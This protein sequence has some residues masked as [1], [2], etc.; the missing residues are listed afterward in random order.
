[1]YIGNTTILPLALQYLLLT[2]EEVKP[3]LVR[4]WFAQFPAVKLVNAYGP[5]EASDDITHYIMDKAPDMERIP[6]GRPLPNM[7]IYIVDYNMQLCPIGMKGEIWVSG[8]GVGRGYLGDDEKTKHV[9]MADPFSEDK[10]VRLY[11]TGDLGSWLADGNIEFF[12]RKDHQVKIRGFR[13]ELEE[14]ENKLSGH[15]QIKAVVVA[16]NEDKTGNKYLCAYI[17]ARSTVLPGFTELKD[18][19][20]ASL[21][22][23][24]IPDYFIQ[25]EKIPLTSNGKIDRKALPA[26]GLKAGENDAAPRT[27]IEKKMAALWAEIL[28]TSPGIDDNFFHLGGHSL[29]AT[30]LISKIHKELNVVIPLAELFKNPTIRGL[31]EYIMGS[32]ADIY[33]SIRPVEKR[34]YYVLSF[35]QKRMYILQKIDLNNIAY[36]MPQMIPLPGEVDNNRL[37]E[38]FR[39]LIKRHESLRTSFH[40]LEEQP[41]QRIHDHVEFK[42]EYYHLSPGYRTNKNDNVY[43]FIRAFDLTKAPLLR[44]GLVKTYEGKQYLLVDMHHIISDGISHQVLHD[45]FMAFY[46]G[47][48]LPAL[49]LQYKDFSQWQND[50][51]EKEKLKYQEE[52]WLKEF[53]GEQPVLDLP[54][55]YPRPLMQ[56]FE[57][58]TLVFE[59]PPGETLALKALAAQQGATLFMV[60]AAVLDILLAKL[61]GQ[62]DIIIGVPVAGRRHVDL[63]KIIGMFVNTL[64]LRNFP[65]GEKSFPGFLNELKNRTLEAFENQ[66]Y[67]FEDLVEKVVTGRDLGRNPLFD[68][69]FMVENITGIKNKSA[70]KPLSTQ[71][72]DNIIKIA[73]FDLEIEAWEAGPVLNIMFGYCTKLFKKE[74]IARFIIY[75]KKIAALVG[76]NPDLKIKDIEIISD[77]EKKQLVVEFNQTAAA[78]PQDKTIMQL[79]AGQAEKS[80]DHIALIGPVQPVQPVQL[81]RHFNLTYRQL[82]EQSDRVAN[83]L[84]EK[85]VLADDIIGIMMERSTQMITAILGIFKSGGAYLPID[86]QS[87]PERIAYMLKDSNAKIVLNMDHFDLNSLKECPRR[88]CHHSNHLAYIIYTSGSTGKPKG[89]M[90]EHTG[91]INHIGAKVID[92]QITKDSVIV[93][94]ASHTFDISV[95]QFFAA[96]TRGG[97]TVIYPDEL[98]LDPARFIARFN[99]DQITILEV[100]PSYLSVIMNLMKDKNTTPCHL[101]YLLVT[102]EEVKPHTVKQW[103]ELHPGIKVVNAYGPTEASDDITHHI[104]DKVPDNDRIPIGKPVQNM[105]I[106]IVD[107]YMQLCPIGVKGEIWVSGIGVG[108]GYLNEVHKTSRVFINDPFAKEEGIRLYKTGDLGRWLADGT[109]E[110]FGRTDYQ[111]KIR[112]FRVEPGEIENRLLNHPGIKEVVVIHRAESDKNAYLGAYIVSDKKYEIAQLREYLAHELPDYM[113]P[114]FFVRVEKIP[115]TPNGKLDRKA[116]PLP[117]VEEISSE[118]TPPGNE[119]EEKLAQIWATVLGT[120]KE[121]ISTRQ[122]FF[123]MG[124]TSLDLI[125][126]L[127]LIH[128]EFGI[129]VTANQIYHNPT[130]QAI[131]KSIE[132]N[133]YVDEPVMLLN[134]PAPKKIF[135]FPPG[136]GF[137]IAYQAL[138]KIINDYSLYSFNFIEDEN[139]LEQYAEI[140]TN[141][142]PTAPYILFGWS[143]AGKLIFEVAAVLEN[144]GFEVS[145]IILADSF[146][147]KV[148]IKNE[149]EQKKEYEN[150][151]N[152]IKFLEKQMDEYGIGYLKAKVLEKNTKYLEYIRGLNKFAVIHA[153]L[154]LLFSEELQADETI[155]R[156]C[157]NE[158]TTKKIMI[159]NGFG[160]HN[161][162]FDGESLEKNAELIKKILDCRE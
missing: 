14:I 95:W 13:I 157:W 70:A 128:K 127:S 55:D 5:T 60:L 59:I 36:N 29:K 105:K 48:E 136:I 18:Y 130:I 149:G 146:L 129:E 161:F 141:L 1:E 51:K 39:K 12:G 35:A 9:F 83:T 93:Q 84:I 82:N 34:A 133:K 156:D 30:I 125:R 112:G 131:A 148:E 144:R 37:E 26:P 52:Y 107:N 94:N 25:I 40:M 140:I 154:H 111:V 73:K 134:Q 32:A 104:M 124:G 62:E 38:S 56:S 79:F 109:I 22:A 31:S 88:G 115:L 65:C 98:V 119:S 126:Q 63:E 153:N 162:M 45:D 71:K 67:Q 3:F 20:A 17:V 113:I 158:F 137:G 6:I 57:G 86:T 151:I 117:E 53:A 102:G 118:Y 139:R 90:V 4:K 54:I 123:E 155:E 80:P 58:D 41:V 120:E 8:A 85:G 50:E 138:A 46:E 61:S 99:L 77:E 110:F 143:A 108:R 91:M 7:N 44:V 160:N 11:K 21:P 33:E 152:G 106:Y 122:N 100:V 101:K 19:L 142:Q 66:E 121:K 96:L 15:P 132:S 28:Q 64:A 23:Y 16:A 103:F 78:Y 43:H 89:V 10:G 68:V 114:S 116:L 69:L 24:M 97:K 42:I 81:V 92:L 159:Y 76:Q 27:A 87:P 150:Y 135:C 145:D 47:K 75:F 74:T 49:W 147:D 2:G 72:V